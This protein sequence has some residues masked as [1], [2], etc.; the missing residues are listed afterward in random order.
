MKRYPK[1]PHQ[2]LSCSAAS[3]SSAGPLFAAGSLSP[4]SPLWRL[5]SP[6]SPLSPFSSC[7]PCTPC[8]PVSPF[9]HPAKLTATIPV[10]MSINLTRFIIRRS[11]FVDWVKG[12]SSRS[13]DSHPIGNFLCSTAD[14][15]GSG[16]AV[17]KPSPTGH[18][19]NH[20]ADPRCF[21]ERCRWS[22]QA[23]SDR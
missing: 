22:N 16:L 9:S 21:S 4:R 15:Q 17:H 1:M 13:I 5:L 7:T 19:L 2:F 12:I 10:A 6:L 23:G 8:G 3:R 20:A 14:N 11:L 18:K